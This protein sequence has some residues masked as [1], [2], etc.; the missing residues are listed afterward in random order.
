MRQLIKSDG[1]LGKIPSHHDATWR[2]VH[3]SI[4]N[5]RNLIISAKELSEAVGEDETIHSLAYQ[6]ALEAA[7]PQSEQQHLNQ[8]DKDMNRKANLKALEKV[9]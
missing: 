9:F 5:H 1:T 6:D 3:Q 4:S 8:D 2:A 7:L